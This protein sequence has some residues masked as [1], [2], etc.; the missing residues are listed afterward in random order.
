M[1][2]GSTTVNGKGVNISG[3][4]RQFVVFIQKIISLFNIS[5]LSISL[6]S[7]SVFNSTHHRFKEA[8]IPAVIAIP[9]DLFSQGY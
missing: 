3:F 8:G 5:S 4:F 7:L 2:L 1:L 9:E 6:L